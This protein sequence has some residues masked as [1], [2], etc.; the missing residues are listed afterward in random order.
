MIWSGSRMLVRMYV[1][2]LGE[3]GRGG[4]M[5]VVGSWWKREG[6][7]GGKG[8]RVVAHRTAYRWE[9]RVA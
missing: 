4:T 8:R 6:V 9:G 5:M 1:V 7:E 3:R 2:V